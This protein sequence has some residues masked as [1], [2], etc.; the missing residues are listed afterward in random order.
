MKVADSK[1]AHRGSRRLIDGQPAF[2]SPRS[3]PGPSGH[4]AGEGLAESAPVPL[5]ENVAFNPRPSFEDISARVQEK[6]LFYTVGDPESWARVSPRSLFERARDQFKAWETLLNSPEAAAVEAARIH[7]HW[8]SPA[9]DP[10]LPSFCDGH[11]TDGSTTDLEY[12][13]PWDEADTTMDGPLA[14]ASRRRGRRDPRTGGY[15]LRSV[16]VQTA[17]SSGG[18]LPGAIRDRPS[19]EVTGTS[20]PHAGRSLPA[21]RQADASREVTGTSV[22]RVG[23]SPGYNSDNEIPRN[24]EP[25]IEALCQK[26]RE[27]D[28]EILKL[29]RNFDRHNRSFQRERTHGEQQR[30]ERS[31]SAYHRSDR[32]HSAQHRSSSRIHALSTR[33]SHRGRSA[34]TERNRRSN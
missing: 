9:G 26:Q 13:H 24:M 5:W 33:S 4:D 20:V 19:R 12:M 17:M 1:K 11:S 27:T 21:S 23:A 32:S 14:K 7:R 28:E 25:L 2:A 3:V 30:S 6:G 22:L 18:S 10:V 8:E 29:T 15:K 34:S 31:H 16:E